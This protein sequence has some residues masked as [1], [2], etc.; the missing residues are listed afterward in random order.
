LDDAWPSVGDGTQLSIVSGGQIT[1]SLYAHNYSTVDM[2]GDA[3]VA[4]YIKLNHNSIVNMFGVASSNI[5]ESYHNSIVNMYGESSVSVVFE[6][7]HDS[8]FNIS[9]DA[10]VGLYILADD[11]GTINVHGN[12]S[13][14]NRI[15]TSDNTTAAK[16]FII[17]HS[18][19]NRLIGEVHCSRSAVELQTQFKPDFPNKSLRKSKILIV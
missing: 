11:N 10:T 7:H 12:A 15:Y 6:A 19:K 18:K 4:K 5:I 16:Y 9:D 2:T 1:E 17:S 8:V 3:S 14:G 13:I